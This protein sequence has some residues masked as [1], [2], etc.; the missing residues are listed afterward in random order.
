[1][2]VIFCFSL[3]YKNDEYLIG[4]D[5]SKKLFGKP[6][7]DGIIQILERIIRKLVQ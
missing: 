1:M 6:P 5:E 7:V 3:L 4:E 2:G